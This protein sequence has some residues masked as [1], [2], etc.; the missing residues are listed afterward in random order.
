[1]DK[2]ASFTALPVKLLVKSSSS[3]ITLH[4][5]AV[6]D[7]SGTVGLYS[8]AGADAS[9]VA[10][11]NLFSVGYAR[12]SATSNIDM[13]AG[14]QIIAGEAAVLISTG[15]ANAAM[16]AETELSLDASK[17]AGGVTGSSPK[18]AGALA[19]SDTHAISHVT[20]AKGASIT[21]GKTANVIA[22]GNSK[23][24]SEAKSGLFAD[25]AAALAFGLDFSNADIKTSVDGSIT[26]LADPV[27]GYT[28]KV[29]IDPTVTWNGVG[30]P[31]AGYVDYTNNRIYIGPNALV[32]EDTITYT[33]RRGT[34]IG[35]LVDG[36]QYF[37]VTD[38]P[39]WI[40]LAENQTNALKA[41]AGSQAGNVVDLRT[42]LGPAT[43][44]NAL[45]FDAS[46][47]DADKN[48]IA[49]QRNGAP[50]FNTF[51][52][53][54]AVV[55][56]EAAGS[57]I[58]GLVDGNTYYILAST[59]EQDLQGNS[60]FADTQVIRLSESENESRGG[61]SIDLGPI[62]GNSFQ[63]VAK[64][65]LDSGYATGIGVVAQLTADNSAT[66]EAGLKSEDTS[67]KTKFAELKEN[68]PSNY[69]SGLF[70]ILG[71]SYSEHASA[72]KAGAS[73]SL[74]VAGA[75]ALT[76]ATADVRTDVLGD[77]VL[78][79]NEDL[80]VKATIDQGTKLSAS[81]ETEPQEDSQGNSSGTSAE[82]SVSVA[83]GIGII[84]NTALATV[85]GGAQLDALRVLR[86]ISE[87]SYPL[88][89]RF[90]Q[91]VPLSW[92]ELTDSIRNEG[93]SAVTKY[94]N[95]NLG[96]VDAFFNTWTAA[97]SKAEKIGVAGSVSVLVYDNDSQAVVQGGAL[98]NQ[99]LAWRDDALNPHPNQAA[100]AADGKGEQVVNVEGAN[101]QQTINM[102]GIFALPDLTLDVV[103]IIGPSQ[104]DAKLWE[105]NRLKKELSLD[106][107]GVSGDTGGAGGAIFISVQ[108]NTT[109]AI[110]EDGAKVYSGADGGLD[111]KA[112]EAILNVN[113][114]QSFAKGKTF[115]IGGTVLY[116]G[117]TS[118]TLAQLGSEAE[119][120]GRNVEITADDQ[121]TTATWAGGI[122]KGESVGVGISVAVNDIDRKTRAVIGDP[123]ALA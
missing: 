93:A 37:V 72:P 121:T 94:L 112:K 60:R 35:G 85:H 51:E 91:F 89:T 98:L 20:V 101:F 46:N 120:T 3:T 68:L 32:D 99:D 115:A 79:S 10:V 12:A 29:E 116:A 65:V 67:P 122:A 59:N 105:K 118:D 78:K 81:S 5:G 100:E 31:P 47:V 69:L 86:V 15:E 97:T 71:K 9:G 73:S 7:G 123:D 8:T 33:N 117:Q 34:S 39:G 1:A 61:V 107:F 54:Q 88:T 42:D 56:H 17:L 64:H 92:G 13:Q 24:E 19:V 87:V 104:K 76:F 27:A 109:H 66:A 22:T 75:L 110:I 95:N 70:N 14:A 11:G 40:K 4:E 26:A 6:L 103:P 114:A 16:T 82:N 30:T 25:G 62:T 49:L 28:V 77:A 52:L 23:S 83:I 57:H 90:D 80:E 55:Y 45:S 58:D 38:D 41:I 63:L 21:A 113:L 48:T 74:S 50:V 18:V 44:D 106:P 108:H 102:T 53:G 96:A 84:N 2:F 43:S 111:I 119:V 36:R